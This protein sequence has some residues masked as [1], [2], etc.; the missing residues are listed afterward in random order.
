MV[1]AVHSTRM[2]HNVLIPFGYQ[3]DP[4]IYARGLYRDGSSKVA[5]EDSRGFG[6]QIVDIVHLNRSA[7]MS[8]AEAEALLLAD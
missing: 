8:Q 5:Y 6:W 7:H 2:A 4:A 1:S 3:K